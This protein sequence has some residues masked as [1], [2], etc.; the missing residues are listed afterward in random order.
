MQEKY[1]IDANNEM[2]FPQ[3]LGDAEKAFALE[4]IMV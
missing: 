4:Q 2:T 3:P 1:K